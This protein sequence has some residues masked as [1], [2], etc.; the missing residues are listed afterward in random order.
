MSQKNLILLIFA[1]IYVKCSTI[2]AELDFLEVNA[3]NND[4]VGLSSAMHSEEKST[5]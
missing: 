1:S 2:N 3:I 4:S 5:L